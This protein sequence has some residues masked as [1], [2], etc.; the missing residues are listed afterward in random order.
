MALKSISEIFVSFIKDS[1]DKEDNFNSLVQDHES[2][3]EELFLEAVSK[4]KSPLEAGDLLLPKTPAPKRKGRGRPK[5]EEDIASN[6]QEEQEQRQ[7]LDIEN[8]NDGPQRVRRAASKA[9]N[10]KIIES[11]RLLNDLSSK[12][13]RPADSTSDATNK[14]RHSNNSDSGVFERLSS[15]STASS[16]NRHSK[17]SLL[18]PV[19]MKQPLPVPEQVE[20]E[21]SDSE[22]E[23]PVQMRQPQ[24]LSEQTEREKLES[25]DG[26]QPQ[27]KLSCQIDTISD[28]EKCKTS[29]VRES[30]TAQIDRKR[31]SSNSNEHTESVARK[32]C[33]TEEKFLYEPI[34]N[35]PEEPQK[36]AD[37][38]ACGSQGKQEECAKLD[39]KSC[40]FTSSSESVFVTQE[41][42]VA[43]PAVVLTEDSNCVVSEASSHVIGLKEAAVNDC[44]DKLILTDDDVASSKNIYDKVTSV[45][46]DMKTPAMKMSVDDDDGMQ[47]DENVTES[48]SSS[49]AGTAE[50]VS[51]V[52]N[53]ACESSQF[54]APLTPPPIMQPKR[55]TRTK[56]R[57]LANA[58]QKESNDV[59]SG[60]VISKLRI[61]RTKKRLVETSSTT[62]DSDDYTRST[63]SKRRKVQKRVSVNKMEDSKTMCLLLSDSED[64][65]NNEIK[66]GRV[67]NAS[68]TSL[69]TVSNK[70]LSSPCR[71]EEPPSVNPSQLRPLQTS[72]H[73]SPDN[74]RAKITGE[75]PYNLPKA[76]LC[77]SPLSQSV[78]DLHLPKSV[79]INN[80]EGAVADVES[81]SDD[82]NRS[83]TD[84]ESVM[85]A[86]DNMQV[87]ANDTEEDTNECSEADDEDSDAD[88]L[89]EEKEQEIVAPPRRMT[90][91]KVRLQQQQQ[92]ESVQLQQ[93]LARAA[94]N[95]QAIINQQ[96]LSAA[97]KKPAVGPPGSGKFSPRPF[98]S[99][100]GVKQLAAAYSQHVAAP[101][102]LP[103]SERKPLLGRSSS[104]SRVATSSSRVTPLSMNRVR[105]FVTASSTDSHHNKIKLGTPSQG[106]RPHN[107][108]CGVRSF[109]GP[110]VLV[111]KSSKP[112]KEQLEEQKQLELLK[113][114]EKEEETLR[115]KEEQ[116]L[117][118]RNETKKR[119]EERMRK[120]QEARL[121]AERKAAEALELLEKEKKLKEQR[122]KED[123]LK[124]KQ[125]LLKKAEEE[126]KRREQERLRK[127][128][129]AV[130]RR[131][132]AEEK[133]RIL[134]EQEEEERKRLEAAR[135]AEEERKAEE[136]RLR[137]KREKERMAREKEE[138]RL[139]KEQTAAAANNV[140]SSVLKPI[141]IQKVL[142]H[143]MEVNNTF[144]VPGNS[145]FTVP[146]NTTFTVASTSSTTP[147]TP[148][149]SYGKV[150]TS[151]QDSYEMTPSMSNENDYGID[152]LKSEDSSDDDSNPKKKVPLWAS[153][154][155]M[156]IALIRQEKEEFDLEAI[157]PRNKVM[158]LPNLKE[159]F[160]VQK[161]TFKVRSS[162]AHWTTPPHKIF[163]NVK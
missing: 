102:P 59:Q 147:K 2:Y 28:D 116:M 75:T 106:S 123:A 44:N 161:S 71:S 103:K 145:T 17:P 47:V 4:I 109:L 8:L 114:K 138:L 163:S 60:E 73:S 83:K 128:E 52:T 67:S 139:L 34:K 46:C 58:D 78:L 88:D 119:N 115:K 14:T 104:T 80:K 135:I 16:G 105:T 65:P 25:Y 55:V 57:Q 108:V 70:R 35:L 113:K 89:S 150:S 137:Q 134:L 39:R 76:T 30:N 127:E 87:V 132:E 148:C 43:V 159:M 111:Q 61:T 12:M 142:N 82:N 84:N 7:E 62:S 54:K 33:R 41:Q 98:S 117:A 157:F 92:E 125:L 13:R 23:G 38:P 124:K 9:A 152:D 101:S 118:K 97:I 51:T 20:E 32:S 96:Q 19:Q 11:Q 10:A 77:F 151:S 48:G 63:R 129:E 133:K 81:C 36:P 31:R 131:E 18:V 93:Q 155:M 136:F 130:R 112:S 95:K 49:S 94:L 110:S 68:I 1:N 40:S 99:R 29:E 64:E 146:G 141:Q 24:P 122:L 154:K 79:Q 126:K 66:K 144:T 42:V 149:T 74:S 50:V 72:N 90:R 85:I 37:Q 22:Q 27:V 56:T 3:L 156:R 53:V 91:S 45:S 143:S 86:T 5:K 153:V 100:T 121:A 69:N 162:S 120:A 140:K 6:D 21:I 160:K 158:V 15:C 107:L 26:E